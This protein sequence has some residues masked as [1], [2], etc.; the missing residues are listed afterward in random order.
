MAA[1]SRLRSLTLLLLVVAAVAALVLIRHLRD[2]A[3]PPPRDLFPTGELLIGIDPS[4]PPFA[5]ATANDLYGLDIDLS[6]ELGRRLDLPVRFVYLGYD[7]LYDAL[8][9]D[10]VDALVAGLLIDLT[11]LND[12]HYSQPYFNAGL[13]LVS[14]KG[15]TRM[16]DLPGHS[17]A[18]EF[19]SEA[20]TQART[21][22]RR[23]LP[24]ETRPYELARYALDA[25]RLGDS[26][27]ALV[28][29]VSAHLYLRD[30]PDWQPRLNQVTDNLYA[31]AT[32][33]RRPEI[34][35]AVNQALQSIIDDGTLATILKR[36]L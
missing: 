18:Y 36:W 26:D 25:A 32:Q 21:W 34:S 11:R 4:N 15:L 9:T 13:V 23:I 24:F 31:I 8:K 5:A 29:A 30:H 3:P 35:A 20:D 1:R 12:V 7:G 2:G 17:L 22:L 14:D 6:R 19:G 16:E 33:S 27:A 10:Q 28:D